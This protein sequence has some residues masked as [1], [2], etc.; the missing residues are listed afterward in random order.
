MSVFQPPAAGLSLLCGR[1]LPTI[2]GT[3]LGRLLILEWVPFINHF[4]PN[5]ELWEQQ[6]SRHVYTAGLRERTDGNTF[7]NNPDISALSL[8]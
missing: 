6:S 1:K 4:S 5:R 3:L 2:P 8:G 7:E